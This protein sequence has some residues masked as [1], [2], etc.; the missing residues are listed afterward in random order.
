M[1]VQLP[2]ILANALLRK[3][4]QPQEAA[5]GSADEAQAARFSKLV[6]FDAASDT[7]PA[8]DASGGLRAPAPAQA[9]ASVVLAESAAVKASPTAPSL[10]DAI[11]HGLDQARNT[12]NEG[13]ASTAALIDPQA[14][15][16]STQR[17]LQF[18]VGIFSV[19]FQQQLLGSVAAKTAQSID[20]LVKMQ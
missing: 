16:V 14:G 18:Q 1:A 13:W 4:P 11:L 3:A 6:Q 20:Q 7:A 17:L 15:P 5:A 8:A 9:K 10:G 12:L 19:G 2:V